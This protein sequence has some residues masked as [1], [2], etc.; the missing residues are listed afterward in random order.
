MSTAAATVA[1]AQPLLQARGLHK[2]F[3]GVKAVA[4]ISFDVPA[5]S[6]FAV[7]GPNGAGK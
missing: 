1:T 7:I 6:I 2:N 5:G 4:D 3:G